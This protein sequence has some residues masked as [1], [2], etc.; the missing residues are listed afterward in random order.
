[1]PLGLASRSLGELDPRPDDV[2]I[3]LPISTLSRIF[4]V[5]QF[6]RVVA[7]MCEP[8]LPVRFRAM[9]GSKGSCVNIYIQQ[10]TSTTTINPALTESGGALV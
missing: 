4:K 9:I 10:Q 6:N 3:E 7:V 2:T 5:T 8:G 1:M